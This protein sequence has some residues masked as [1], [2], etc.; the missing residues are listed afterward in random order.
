[1]EKCTYCKDK[2]KLHYSGFKGERYDESK[3]MIVLHRADQRIEK[4]EEYLQVLS[5]T[6]TGKTLNSLLKSCGLDFQDV[7]ITNF[8]KCIF[9]KTRDPGKEVYQNCRNVL[10]RQIREIDPK[11][12]LLFGQKPYENLF[13]NMSFEKGI[14]DAKGIEV[15]YKG[16]PCLI[17]LHPS[18]I[19]PYSHERKITHYEPIQDFLNKYNLCKKLTI[20]PKQK[21]IEF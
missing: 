6:W 8:V 18:K 17:N 10:E 7:F 12:I 14:L 13:N 11:V 3:I 20:F 16:I 15:N 1:M 21:K 4:P 5:R 2:I 9:Y 19:Y